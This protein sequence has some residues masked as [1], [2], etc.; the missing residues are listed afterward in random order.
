M[1]PGA[2]AA[3]EAPEVTPPPES[4]APGAA[5]ET[6]DPTRGDPAPAHR[7][8]V[9]AFCGSV[10]REEQEWCLECGVARTVLHRAPDWRLPVA[11]VAVVLVAAVI[12]F[13]VAIVDLGNTGGAAVRPL[14][15]SGLV[16][17]PA[18]TSTHVPTPGVDLATWPVGL[19]G[20]TVELATRPDQASADAEARALA[21]QHVTGLGVLDA[22][23]HPHLHTTGWIVFSHR[24]A[25]QS[26][27]EQAAARLAS[28][29]HPGVTAVEVA[30]PGGI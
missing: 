6:W 26:A 28:A 23:E 29:G 1:T 25:L 2:S 15:A 27:A 5:L 3:G 10:L 4:T 11:V 30:P 13:L 9:C 14:S 19:S 12:A 17:H 20:W 16:H 18:A 8:D 24:Y 22:G 21:T 7:Q